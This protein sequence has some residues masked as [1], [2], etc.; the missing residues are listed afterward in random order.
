MIKQGKMS[1]FGMKMYKLGLQKPTH[2]HGIPKNPNMPKPLK[3]ELEKPENIEAKTAFKNYSKSQKR[4]FYR[5][6]LS[7]KLPQ[8]RTQRINQTVSRAF[9]SKKFMN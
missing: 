9:Q 5:W 6:I 4:M 2:D 3:Q 8:T 1:D 7:A